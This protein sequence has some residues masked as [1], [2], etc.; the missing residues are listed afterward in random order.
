MPQRTPKRQKIGPHTARKLVR[1]VL[2]DV[3][4]RHGLTEADLLVRDRHPVAVAAR[5]E[6]FAACRSLGLTLQA[7]ASVGGW[8]HTTVRAGAMKGAK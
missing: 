8:D 2:S 3:A 6:A 5:H 7:I 4:L 1:S